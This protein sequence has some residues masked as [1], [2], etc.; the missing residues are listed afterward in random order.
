[1]HGHEPR[2]VLSLRSKADH[3]PGAARTPS[4]GRRVSFSDIPETKYIEATSKKRA[5]S[6][7]REVISDARKAQK[8][9]TKFHHRPDEMTCLTCANAEV[10]FFCRACRHGTCI[11]CYHFFCTSGG[12]V[13]AGFAQVTL[14][15][16]R[17]SY[18]PGCEAKRNKTQ[19]A[20][21]T[22]PPPNK[23]NTKPQGQPIK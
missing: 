21:N 10:L 12:A 15:D 7:A 19:K 1:M 14:V 9:P 2:L 17:S 8:A 3:A 5:T 20:T 13:C 16:L 11:D 23:P 6:R 18:Q 4:E 22:K